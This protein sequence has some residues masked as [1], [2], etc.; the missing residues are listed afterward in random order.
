MEYKCVGRQ[1]ELNGPIECN[2]MLDKKYVET[3][4]KTCIDCMFDDYCDMLIG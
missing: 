4:G 1:C 3:N 2:E